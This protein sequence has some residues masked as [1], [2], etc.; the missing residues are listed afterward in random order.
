MTDRFLLEMY[1]RKAGFTQ[2]SISKAMGITSV[3]FR[4]KLKNITEF[5]QSEIA[6]L[7]DHLNLTLEEREKIFFRR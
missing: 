7:S 1:L 3:S 2:E 5:K 4:R 6:F